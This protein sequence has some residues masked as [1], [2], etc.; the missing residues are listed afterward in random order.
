MHANKV[1]SPS[2]LARTA[3]NITDDNL[4][5]TLLPPIKKD[6]VAS[7]IPPAL[8]VTV[9]FTVLTSKRN[10][11]ADGLLII[12]SDCQVAS[13]GTPI[14]SS[15]KRDIIVDQV[16]SDIFRTLRVDLQVSG[17]GTALAN[18][19]DLRTNGKTSVLTTSR[20][21]SIACDLEFGV[22][23]V[24][25]R[26]RDNVDALNG[27]IRVDSNFVVCARLQRNLSL[28]CTSPSWGVDLGRVAV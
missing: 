16:Q 13:V 24:L 22:W 21:A 3:I 9:Q 23:I 25:S 17:D 28:S 14:P 11:N 18:V 12:K 27:D 6:I 7:T 2:S 19:T 1:R 26:W 4:V 20:T 5:L 10:L 15:L 8:V